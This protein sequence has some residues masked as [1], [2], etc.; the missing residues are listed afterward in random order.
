M[1][2]DRSLYGGLMCEV[3]QQYNDVIWELNT[4]GGCI[5]IDKFQRQNT[6]NNII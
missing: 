3:L 6:N 4:T 1:G 5:E 2:I